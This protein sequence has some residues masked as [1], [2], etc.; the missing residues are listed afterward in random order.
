MRRSR[1]LPL[2]AGRLDYIIFVSGINVVAIILVKK[3]IEKIMPFES[4]E[5]ILFYSHVTHSGLVSGFSLP[6]ALI[7]SC[8]VYNLNHDNPV[9][10]L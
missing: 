3:L 6:I 9:W 7:L 1:N 2:P 4:D 5:N 10:V 8:F